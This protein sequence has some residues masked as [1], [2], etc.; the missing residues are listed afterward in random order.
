MPLPELLRAAAARQGRDREQQVLRELT[1]GD[2]K[3]RYGRTRDAEFSFPPGAEGRLGGGGPEWRGEALR[4]APTPAQFG[5]RGLPEHGSIANPFPPLG[6]QQTVE[7]VMPVRYGSSAGGERDRG[8]DVRRPSRG[9]FGDDRDVSGYTT[10]TRPGDPDDPS[11]QGLGYPE[12]APE[13]FDTAD[14]L[15]LADQH[16]DE[17]IGLLPQ[18]HSGTE[19]AEF[20]ISH[21]GATGNLAV[22]RRGDSRPV[23]FIRA[24]PGM[25]ARDY[26]IARDRRSGRLAVLRRRNRDR[27]LHLQHQ[28]D[29]IRRRPTRD[30]QAKERALL[31]NVNA[32]NAEFWRRPQSPSDFWGKR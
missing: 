19:P 27:L 22:W 30:S 15:D 1:E 31:A 10:T 32:T 28:A 20:H 12:R 25:S 23:G 17:P 13:D 5:G 29:Q 6:P 21:D 3:M 11:R 4:E 7:T 2:A 26:R 14:D 24:S 9:H 8:R 18:Q 16:D